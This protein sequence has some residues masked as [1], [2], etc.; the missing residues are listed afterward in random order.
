MN[1]GK[2]NMI[3]LTVIAVATLLV[4]VVGAT[5]A[6]FNATVPGS[7]SQKTIEVTSGTLFVDT[8]SSV[9]GGN[10]IAPNATLARR[11]IKVT[12]YV[13]GSTN[14]NY[15]AKLVIKENTYANGELVYTITSKNESNN[16]STIVAT[17]APVA[18]P[19]GASTI[20][21]GSGLFAG[22]AAKGAKHTYTLNI[23]YVNEA[24]ET[25]VDK[26]FNATI[27]VEQPSK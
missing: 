19:A 3:L 8:N 2:G 5:F 26:K 1:S 4:S 18:I 13:T 7:E 23:Q 9:V 6:Y 25:A 17:S 24:G 16:G 14:L 10:N 22:P 27:S 12:G 21:L 11:D 20:N 15:D